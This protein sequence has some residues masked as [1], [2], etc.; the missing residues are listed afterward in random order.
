MW[1]FILSKGRESVELS[2]PEGG[3]G[4]WIYLES[5]STK[6]VPMGRLDYANWDVLN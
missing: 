5:H 6:T 4:H 3:E 1:K 2:A